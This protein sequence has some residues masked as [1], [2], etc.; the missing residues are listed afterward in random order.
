MTLTK[1]GLLSSWLTSGNNLGLLATDLG[2]VLI[3]KDTNNRPTNLVFVVLNS[4]SVMLDALV[5]TNSNT[6][7]TPEV[8]VSWRCLG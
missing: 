8:T 5:L 2:T 1:Y 7:M 4:V 6:L 3:E